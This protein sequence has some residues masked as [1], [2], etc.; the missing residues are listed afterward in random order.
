MFFCVFRGAMALGTSLS[1]HHNLSLLTL[2]LDFNASLGDE[3]VIN[4]CKGVRT[5]S[6]LKQVSWC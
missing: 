3:G 2:K 5:N 1:R 4:L 6:T